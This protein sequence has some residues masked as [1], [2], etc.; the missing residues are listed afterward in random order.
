MCNR[1]AAHLTPPPSTVSKLWIVYKETSQQIHDHTTLPNL[2]PS[3]SSSSSSTNVQTITEVHGFWVFLGV[4]PSLAGVVSSVLTYTGHMQDYEEGERLRSSS[5]DIDAIIMSPF[6]ILTR[7]SLLG[8]SSALLATSAFI[9]SGI[10][11]SVL[12]Q[13]KRTRHTTPLMIWW[14]LYSFLDYGPRIAR[15]KKDFDEDRLTFFA[16]VFRLLICHTPL[17]SIAFN[18]RKRLSLFPRDDLSDFFSKSLGIYKSLIALLLFVTSRMNICTVFHGDSHDNI[19]RGEHEERSMLCQNI[20]HIHI[21]VAHV[22]RFTP[23]LS[24][25][26]TAIQDASAL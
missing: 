14:V 15:G 23:L 17:L 6:F 9:Y 20:N 2:A 24:Q 8:S 5:P 19:C 11:V 1:L 25:Q 22:T 21:L 16:L 12:A 26:L 3:P 13:P 10:I 7:P 18:L 4:L